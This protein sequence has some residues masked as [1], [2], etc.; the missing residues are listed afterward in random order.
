[1]RID[2]IERYLADLEGTL[3]LSKNDAVLF[4][5][6]ERAYQSAGKLEEFYEG[7]GSVATAI[8]EEMGINEWKSL[9]NHLAKLEL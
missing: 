7:A 6:K 9:Y 1:M 8:D 2:G 5:S 4:L 3:S